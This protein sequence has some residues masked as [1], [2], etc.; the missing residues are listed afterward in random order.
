MVK[1]KKSVVTWLGEIFGASHNV[2][3]ESLTAE[4]YNQ[5]VIDAGKYRDSEEAKNKDDEADEEEESEEETEEETSDPKNSDGKANTVEARLNKLEATLKSSQTALK[6]E[7]KTNKSLN[8]KVTELEG[9]LKVS[10]EQK[11]K[12]R[13]SVN[14]LGDEDVTNSAGV[15]EHLT[16]ADIEARASW[17]RE[18]SDK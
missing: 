7:Q 11:T 13:N 12:L 18:N 3:S 6:A 4:E 15:E 5:L 2:V 10:E 16:Q 17:N 9:K 1:P 14:Q 8:S